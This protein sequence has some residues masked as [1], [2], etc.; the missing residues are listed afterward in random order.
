M[1]RREFITLLGG[2]AAWPPAARAQTPAR[3]RRIGILSAFAEDDPEARRNITVFRQALENL[4]W[5]D[6]GNARIDYRW[7]GADAARIR[8]YA[9]E[10]LGLNPDVFLVSTA[11]WTSC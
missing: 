4:G 8:A 3:I 9:L 2:A 6:G 7:G 11:A 5:T 1:I 10:L